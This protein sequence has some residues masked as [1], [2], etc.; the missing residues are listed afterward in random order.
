M[1]KIKRVEEIDQFKVK[2]E[3]QELQ[4]ARQQW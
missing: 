4:E 3:A 2:G 1:V